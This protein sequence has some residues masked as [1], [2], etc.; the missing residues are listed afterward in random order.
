MIVIIR[1]KPIRRLRRKATVAR[2]LPIRKLQ[3]IEIQHPQPGCPQCVAQFRPRAEEG[4]RFLIENRRLRIHRARLKERKHPLDEVVN[5]FQPFVRPILQL[6]Q[7]PA[8]AIW[9]LSAKEA[10]NA[11]I[12]SHS[13][14][15]YDE[16]ACWDPSARE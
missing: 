5:R 2:Y 16:K 12:R 14:R 11:R 4:N 10:D 7:I 13:S 1:T 15:L 6:A 9:Q 8:F 3:P